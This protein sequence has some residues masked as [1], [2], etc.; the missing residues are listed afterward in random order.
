M[1]ESMEAL[2][3]SMYMNNVPEQW[4]KL[5]WPSKRELGSWITNLQDRLQQLADWTQNPMEVPH[6]TWL[7][8][9]R[10]P[11][12][13]LTAIMQETAQQNKLELGKLMITTEVTKLE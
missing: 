8:G 13:F 11:Q 9:L 6:C 1:S 5:G 2:Q 12:S 4:A 7:S 10:N 3:N